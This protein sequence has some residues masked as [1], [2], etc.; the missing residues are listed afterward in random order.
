MS[1]YRLKEWAIMNLLLVL[2]LL[3][4][5][6]HVWVMLALVMI[7]YATLE[8]LTIRAFRRAFVNGAV[9]EARGST[10]DGKVFVIAHGYPYRWFVRRYI[11]TRC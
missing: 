8:V 10:D 4:L 7:A 3:L 11:R 1:P 6:Q 9:R 5:P 2:V